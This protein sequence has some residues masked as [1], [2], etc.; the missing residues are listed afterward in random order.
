MKNK[1]LLLIITLFCSVAVA[2]STTYWNDIILWG[3]LYL[4]ALTPNTVPYLNG[5]SVLTAS[6]TTP[7]E[8][9]FVH[10][11]TSSLCGINQSCTLTNK[12]IAAGSNTITG[13]TNSN[14]SGS[15]AVSNA[16]LA[17]VSNNTIK[18]NISGS[19]ATPS[20]NSLTAIIDNALGSTQ[21][22]VLYRGASAWAALG[23]GS[24][25]N[26]LTAA[27]GSANPSWQAP[28]G[29][30]PVWSYTAQSSNYSASVNDYI[31]ASGAT[32]TITLPT[33][34]GNSG[35]SIVIQDAGTNFKAIPLLTTSGQTIGGIASGSYALQTVGERLILISDGAN[36]QIF[37]HDTSTGWVNDTTATIQFITFTVTSANATIAATYAPAYVFTI[38]AGNTA[39][40]AAVYSN[41]GNNYTLAKAI[42]VGDTTAVFTGA[43]APTG[44]GTLTYVSGTHTGGNLAFSAV[45]G[46][47]DTATTTY[48]IA[49]TLAAGTTLI[50]QGIPTS[51]NPNASG[52]LVKVSG[53]GD[54]VITYSAFTGTAV[55][56]VNASTTPP[57]WFGSPATNSVTWQRSGNTATIRFVWS[58]A[59]AGAS[60]G[61]GDY[62]F[63]I[64]TGMVFDTTQVPV[65]TGGIGTSTPAA[66]FAS[67]IG[68]MGSCE[69]ASALGYIPY[70]IPYTSTS[71]RA[72]CFG[73][74]TGSNFT[75]GLAF[76]SS[77]N[78]FGAASTS[79]AFSVTFTGPI[80]GW[81]P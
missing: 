76:G 25:G 57:V 23:P 52:Q 33:A 48:T 71:Y 65:F 44:S 56:T 62:T 35:K 54:A 45:A 31:S 4:S 70:I 72:F 36:W 29:A 68:A 17:S 12:T 20:D 51:S 60:N 3:N 22:S 9:G 32:T 78:F 46:N 6:A 75:N 74:T 2:A 80:S 73:T 26:I 14:L 7:T 15:A 67:I 47:A 53:T 11:A 13:L 49:K 43:A 58:A 69:G 64:P 79:Q 10:G 30:T 27:G 42:L 59:T 1:S 38:T 34:V 63:S 37:N 50:A 61:S 40:V 39:S 55:S 41:N 28:A 16:N 19:T 81:Q 77:N 21:G 8:L 66:N 24:N 18:S 5:S